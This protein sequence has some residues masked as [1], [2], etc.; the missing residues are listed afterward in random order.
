MNPISIRKTLIASSIALALGAPAAEAALVTNVFGPYTWGTDSANLTMLASNG[1]VVAGA[2]TNDVSMTWDGNA[3]TSSTDYTGPGGPANVT[4]S[5]T[6]PVFGYTWTAHDI[7]MFLP[8]SYSFDIGLQTA[9]HPNGYNTESGALN[10]TVGAG[11]LGMHMLFDWNGS[12]NI[13]VFVV[14][15]LNSVFGSGLLYGTTRD[16]LGDLMCDANYTGTVVMNCLYDGHNY[17]GAGAPTQ[18]QPWMF[19]SADGNGDGI[20]GIPMAPGGPVPGFS[21]NFNINATATPKPVPVPAPLWLL[22]SGLMGLLGFAGR[23]KQ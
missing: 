19:A 12:N 4:A 1:G 16:A 11:Q 3:Y 5:S 18:D 9:A 23:R 6:T 17:G 2:S 8:G 13:D 14:G 22:V 10:V 20:M 15:N 21:A 7:Q